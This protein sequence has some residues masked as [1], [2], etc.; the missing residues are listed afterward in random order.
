[1]SE[2]EQIIEENLRGEQF[3][4]S[5]SSD[6]HYLCDWCSKGVP[7]KKN[8]TISFYLC[9]SLIT[10]QEYKS[11]AML[12]TYCEDCS[13][14]L[15]YFPCRGYNE[16]RVVSTLNEDQ[17]I[18]DPEVTDVSLKSDGVP[19]DPIDVHE[20][21]SGVPREV[22]MKQASEIEMAPENIITFL[23]SILSEVAVTSIINPDGSIDREILNKAKQEFREGIKKSG[24]DRS[25]FR[26]M[27]KDNKG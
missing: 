4:S 2:I 19:W 5:Y 16:I 18:Q 26:E 17:I 21:I 7:Y 23:E 24:N 22:S 12:A 25:S 14:R 15:L 9:D 27:A 11:V 3:N 20:K 6:E 8:P 13:S 10:G 1:M